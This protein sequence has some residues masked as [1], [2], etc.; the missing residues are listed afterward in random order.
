MSSVAT[1]IPAYIPACI[2]VC[3]AG[4]RKYNGP[5][6]GDAR[7]PMMAIGYLFLVVVEEL[8]DLVGLFLGL[9]Y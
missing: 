9:Y 1:Y 8:V 7:L 4:G 5:D 3:I 6:E 2:N